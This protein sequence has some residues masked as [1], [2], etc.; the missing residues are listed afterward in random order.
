MLSGLD[1]GV[2][3]PEIC[4]ELAS[5][6]WAPGRQALWELAGRVGKPGQA[7]PLGKGACL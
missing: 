4:A 3:R 5:K 1:T 2:Y 7:L 6:A